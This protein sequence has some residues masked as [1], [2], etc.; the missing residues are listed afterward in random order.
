MTFRKILLCTSI[1]SSFSLSFLLHQSWSIS[2]WLDSLFLVGLVLLVICAIMILIEAEFFVAFITSCKHFFA[3][4]S[5]KEQVIRE[6]E[7]HSYHKVVYQKSFP[8]R[9]FF[10]EIG[11]VFCAIS[12]II[13]TTIYYFG[14]R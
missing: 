3:R 5:K 2:K 8:S 13:S 9:K 1:L 14:R 4:I 12:L 10:F 6:I 11:I 7:N